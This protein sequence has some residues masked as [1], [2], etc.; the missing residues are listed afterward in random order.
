[1]Y[2]AVVDL[3]ICEGGSNIGA[4]KTCGQIII[5]A[6]SLQSSI[7]HLYKY[8]NYP[9]KNYIFFFYPEGDWCKSESP[10]IVFMYIHVHM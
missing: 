1:M 10:L 9:P 2:I 5:I 4:C 8:N 6:C 7:L 3:G